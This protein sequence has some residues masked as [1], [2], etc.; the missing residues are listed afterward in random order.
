[1]YFAWG[2]GLTNII[3][4]N[5]IGSVFHNITHGRLREEDRSHYKEIESEL[6]N[7]SQKTEAD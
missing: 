5:V 3:L 4:W 1:M 2:L 6:I 7:L